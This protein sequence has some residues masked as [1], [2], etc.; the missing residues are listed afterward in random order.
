MKRKI[1]I[2]ILAVMLLLSSC[3][4]S[5]DSD[6]VPE[7]ENLPKGDVITFAFVGLQSASEDINSVSNRIHQKILED[8]GI[9]EILRR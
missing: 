9:N 4:K 1:I 8:F 3:S 5:K 6:D 2:V 7:G